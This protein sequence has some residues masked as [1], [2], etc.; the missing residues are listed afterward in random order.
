MKHVFKSRD[1]S[2]TAF[3]SI[4]LL[5]LVKY[6]RNKSVSEFL[7]FRLRQRSFFVSETAWVK[8]PEALLPSQVALA[9][10]H[11]HRSLN[12]YQQ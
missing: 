2:Y 7:H 6:E 5:Y 3:N 4:F 8:N 9:L 11:F 12:L 10:P 1:M